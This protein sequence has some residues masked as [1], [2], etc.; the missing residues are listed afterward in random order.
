MNT[1]KSKIDAKEIGFKKAIDKKL[2]DLNAKNL[3]NSVQNGVDDLK[4]AAF[5]NPLVREFI[6]AKKWTTNGELDFKSGV[7]AGM[8]AENALLK[9]T[10]PGQGPK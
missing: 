10:I 9:I 1:V 4:V 6:T 2:A 8:V 3:R 5:T 7:G